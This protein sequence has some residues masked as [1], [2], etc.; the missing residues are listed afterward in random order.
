MLLPDDGSTPDHPNVHVTSF[1][2][3]RVALIVAGSSLGNVPIFDVS[4][5]VPEAVTRIWPKPRPRVWPVPEAS[6]DSELEWITGDDLRLFWPFTAD[7]GP[8]PPP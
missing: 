7:G 8:T 3:G 5:L 4:E 1:G 6:D 2:L